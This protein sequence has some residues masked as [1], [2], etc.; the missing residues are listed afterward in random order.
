MKINKVLRSMSEQVL[1]K[2]SFN[3]NCG[4]GLSLWR[5]KFYLNISS[6][7]QSCPGDWNVQPLVSEDVLGMIIYVSL[8][9]VMKL[10]LS[11]AGCVGE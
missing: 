5:R 4:P 11:T 7:D 3:L 8:H 10:A 6:Q 1:Q 2:Y 9:T